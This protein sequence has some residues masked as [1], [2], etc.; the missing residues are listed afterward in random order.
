[1]SES[2]FPATEAT[3]DDAFVITLRDIPPM[4]VAFEFAE[5][6]VHELPEWMPGAMSR[7]YQAADA[8]GGVM[9]TDALPYL[10][11]SQ[12]APEPVFI[13]I[14]DGNPEHGAMRVEVTAPVVGVAPDAAA[15]N[16]ALIAFPSH[17]EAFVRLKRSQA[18]PA[19]LGK[20]YEAVERWALD[21]GYEIA[22]APREVYWTDFMG[23]SPHDEVCDIAWPIA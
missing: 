3:G 5:R 11:R 8:L 4:V 23:A 22:A 18:E 16:D 12:F 9:R 14:Y 1:M 15:S 17:R 10:D 21:H 2:Q 13:V 7:V 20:A 6:H 19:D